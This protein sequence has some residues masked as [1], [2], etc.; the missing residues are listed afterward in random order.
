MINEYCDW[1]GRELLSDGL[2]PFAS[3]DYSSDA[4]IAENARP[5]TPITRFVVALHAIAVALRYL[6]SLDRR[7][8]LSKCIERSM[9][10]MTKGRYGGIFLDIQTKEREK[11][12]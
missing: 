3:I 2:F 12:S 9:V 10:T 6:P 1:K 7:E 4:P 8:I 5:S 11:E